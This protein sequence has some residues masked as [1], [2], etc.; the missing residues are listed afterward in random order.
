MMGP[1]GVMIAVSHFR[2]LT[3]LQAFPL[4]LLLYSVANV[5]TAVTMFASR[6]AY[7]AATSQRANCPP[8]GDTLPH[9]DHST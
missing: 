4:H 5:F 7:G 8:V 9:V 2:F 6:T 3:H 1:S